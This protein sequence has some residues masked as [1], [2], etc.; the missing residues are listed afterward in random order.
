MTDVAVAASTVVRPTRCA[1]FP[2]AEVLV[3]VGL[4]T[5]YLVIPPGADPHVIWACLLLQYVLLAAALIRPVTVRPGV[6]CYVTTE[7]LFLFLA[8]L[9]F[10]YPYQLHV[11]GIY[12]VSRS[13]FFRSSFAE[14]SNGAILLSTMAV[15]GFRAGL[16]VL[17]MPQSSHGPKEARVGRFDRIPAQSLILP[18][19]ALQFVLISAYLAF[20]WRGAGESRYTGW[21]AATMVASPLVE[22]V[23]WAIIVL[24]M[25]SMALWV[26]PNS[27]TG[28]ATS[29]I[30]AVSGLISGCW[31]LRLLIN[32][33]RNAFLLIALVG[34]AGVLTFRIRLGRW[35]LGLLV[36][37]AVAMYNA[38]EAVRAG[39]VGSWGDLVAGMLGRTAS[40]TYNGD[41]SFNISTVSVRAVLAGVPELI[42]YGYGFYKLI[43]VGGIIPFIRGMMVP[44]DVTYTQSSQVVS[45]LLLGSRPR[46][47]VGSNVIVDVYADLGALAVPLLL[48]MLGLFVAYVQR[49]VMRL[50]ES[51]WRAVLYLVTLALIAE[52]PRYS[53][54]FAVRP[55]A[56]VVGLF[57]VVSLLPTGRRASA[58]ETTAPSARSLRPGRS[59]GTSLSLRSW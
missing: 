6:T 25:V 50:P 42:D 30:L 43:G 3:V 56:W 59:A 19:F 31:A 48:F 5:V 1:V 34:V 13:A 33:D 32:G 45:E 9:V 53:L 17:R 55:L 47:G 16:R 4:F 35:A 10:F 29:A 12:D 37:G 24:C 18:I 7:F 15:F 54:D 27:H 39:R 21:D 41:T 20:G 38:A 40:A 28:T 22:G 49:G 36:V 51:P 57:F 58:N 52:T 8:Y 23:Y 46:W 14:Q 2:M 26:L 44:G 11:L